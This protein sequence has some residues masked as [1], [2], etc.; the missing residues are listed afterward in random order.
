MQHYFV[1]SAIFATP[2]RDRCF[3]ALT[4]L[5]LF[6]LTQML[7]GRTILILAALQLASASSWDPLSSHGEASV[8]KLSHALAPK[9]NIVLWQIQ[10]WK[11]TGCVIFFAIWT[12]PFSLRFRCT[13]TTRVRSPLP[14]IQSSTTAP[15]ISMSTAT[16][17]ARPTRREPYHFLT[18]HQGPSLLTS[19]RRHRRHLS[20]VRLSPN[21]RCLIH[22]E[23]AGGGGC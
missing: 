8:K 15:S 21:S 4:R 18:L 12:F 5:C 16:S 19:S 3:T 6:E 9:Q 14:P 13:V 17:L 2:S 11:F 7:G 10:L 20:S 23:F 1:S 22:H